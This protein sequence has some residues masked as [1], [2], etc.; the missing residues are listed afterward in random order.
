M[1]TGAREGDGFCT[2]STASAEAGELAMCRIEPL[3]APT[4][5]RGM[6]CHQHAA[7]EDADFVGEDVDVEDPPPRR[8]RHAIQIAADAHHAFVRGPSLQM[9]HRPVGRAWQGLECRLFLGEGLIDDPMG[10]GMHPRIGDSIQPMAELAVEVV[11]IAEDP[12]RKKSSR[13]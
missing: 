5:E 8:I 6:T 3:L 7:L 11:Q 2:A 4:F 13:M 1:V 12:P 9:Q 10:R